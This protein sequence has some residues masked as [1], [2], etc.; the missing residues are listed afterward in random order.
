MNAN[1]PAKCSA[2]GHEVEAHVAPEVADARVSIVRGY[3]VTV[4]QPR[5]VDAEDRAR[6][7]REV[8][9]VVVDSLKRK[10]VTR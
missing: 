3:R 7:E 4:T 1:S 10:A 6:R 2:C 5:E 8:V 9:A